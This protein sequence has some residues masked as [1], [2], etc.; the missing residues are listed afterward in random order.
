M[1]LQLLLRALQ[2]EFEILPMLTQ[3][4]TPVTR[5]NMKLERAIAATCAC[6][7]DSTH[8]DYANNC[9]GS[10]EEV[11]ELAMVR[12]VLDATL[13]Y[14]HQASPFCMKSSFLKPCAFRAACF[15]QSRACKGSTGPAN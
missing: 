8:C 3:L 2:V 6:K 5:C 13:T 7:I 11:M 4:H 9:A 15:V 14:N 12:T 1:D 10:V